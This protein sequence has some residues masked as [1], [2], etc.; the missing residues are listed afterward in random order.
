MA[1]DPFFD[2]IRGMQAQLDAVYRQAKHWSILTAFWLVAGAVSF[3]WGY[4]FTGAAGTAI[5]GLCNL[6]AFRAMRAAYRIEKHRIECIDAAAERLFANL[7][8]H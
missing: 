8:R 6:I 7:E 1:D 4:P 2:I 5:G 3:T